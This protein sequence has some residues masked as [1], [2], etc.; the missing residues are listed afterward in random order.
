MKCVTYFS[1]FIVTSA[2]TIYTKLFKSNTRC[3]TLSETKL[4]RFVDA[5][6]QITLKDLQRSVSEVTLL[7][8][9]NVGNFK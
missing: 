7:I 8:Y 9:F 5:S 3:N 2:E 1:R 6:N 4:E